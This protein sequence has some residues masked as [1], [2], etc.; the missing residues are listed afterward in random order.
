MTDEFLTASWNMTPATAD[1]ARFL[2]ENK[3]DFC[4]E[5]LLGFEMKFVGI[6]WWKW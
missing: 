6:W 1:M 5:G 3:E 2:T 4:F